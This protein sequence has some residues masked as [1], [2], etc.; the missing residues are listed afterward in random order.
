MAY[1]DLPIQSLAGLTMPTAM[2][3]LGKNLAQFPTTFTPNA[4]NLSAL[5]LP[6]N[7]G[8]GLDGSSMVSGLGSQLGAMPNSMLSPN[9]LNGT[10][11]TGGFF[12]NGMGLGMNLPTFNAAIGGL[13]S[14]GNLAMGFKSYGLA[15]D[16]AKLTKEVTNTNLN[17][18]ITAANG[19]LEDR[20]RTRAQMNGQS[21]ADWRAEY[22][23]RKFKRG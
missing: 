18:S 19:A 16:Q 21:E 8:F 10:V 5:A 17:N 7:A 4:G 11:G 6:Q 12:G 9:V 2:G 3:N 23:E 20:L 22:E 14:L 13:T 1:P 15:K